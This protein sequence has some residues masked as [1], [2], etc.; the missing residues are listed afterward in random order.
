MKSLRLWKVVAVGL[1]LSLLATTVRAEDKAALE[2]K[3]RAALA[4]AGAKQ[5][6]ATAVPAPREI[7]EQLPVVIYVGCEG[8]ECRGAFKLQAKDY[9]G[10]AAPAVVV[11]YPVGDRM[12][13]EATFKGCPT[14]AELQKAVDGAARKTADQK[15]MPKEKQSKAAGC[16]CGDDCKCAAG[17]CPG[18]CPVEPKAAAAVVKAPELVVTGYQ[19]QKV[20]VSG[21]CQFVQVPV[22]GYR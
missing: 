12:N 22:Y 4:L 18:K 2:R 21:V 5:P 9:P 10:V 8:P 3:V 7:G 17:E 6:D 14:K 20:C 19:W 15:P 11:Q 13:T 1:V 16:V